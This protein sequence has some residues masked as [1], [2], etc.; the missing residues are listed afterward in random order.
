MSVKIRDDENQYMEQL[1]SWLVAQRDVPLEEMGSFFEKRI[2]SYDE[3]MSVWD[4]AYRKLARLVPKDIKQILDLGCGTGL[5]LDEIFKV[6]PDLSVTGVDLCLP[7]LEK[8]K[9]KHGDKKLRLLCADY[10]EADLGEKCYDCVISVES[11]H[12]FTADKKREL[13]EKIYSALKD[14]GVFIE[15]D[16]IACCED[17]EKILLSEYLR[18]RAAFAAGEDVFVHFDI[19]LTAEH[20]TQVIKSAGFGKAEILDSVNGAVFIKAKK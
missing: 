1:K 9:E 19:P 8:L 2:G 4:E 11:F 18:K 15:C 17:E 13:Y 12:H 10:F 6:H 3:H 16:Y 20:E 14:G 7:M 5:E